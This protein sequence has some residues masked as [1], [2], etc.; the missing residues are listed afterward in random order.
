MSVPH[1]LSLGQIK[2]V[3]NPDPS[4]WSVGAMGSAQMPSS[5]SVYPLSQLPAGDRGLLCPTPG[6]ALS[7]GTCLPGYAPSPGM[8]EANDRPTCNG[9]G[10]SPL[11]SAWDGAIPA[12]KLCTGSA[13]AAWLP[14]PPCP[15]SLAPLQVCLPGSIPSENSSCDSLAAERDLCIPK[16]AA[17]TVRLVALA[18]PSTKTQAQMLRN[19]K[20]SPPG[21]VLLSLPSPRLRDTGRWT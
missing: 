6:T 15:A 19:N 1:F 7:P 13:E 17:A 2:F 16:N 10:L 14:P 20:M 5:W 11:P 12:R 18:S 4:A 9:R 8:A 21:I 3:G